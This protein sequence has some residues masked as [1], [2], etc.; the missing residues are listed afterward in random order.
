M[1][2]TLLEIRDRFPVN[3]L[4]NRDFCAGGLLENALETGISER[5][6]SGIGQSESFYYNSV[7]IRGFSP[8]HEELWSQD[9]P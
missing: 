9:Y 1:H 3:I 7:I 6:T 4:S 8:S 5:E 2:S